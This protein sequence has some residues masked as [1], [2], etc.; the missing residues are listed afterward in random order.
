MIF[1][2]SYSYSYTKHYIKT[3]KFIQ[4]VAD[5]PPITEALF[6]YFIFTVCF[7][8]ILGLNN[9]LYTI[10]SELLT[11]IVTQRLKI[12]ITRT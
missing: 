7:C 3:K 6:I 5:T 9:I 8:T 11:F 2:I 10:Y 1:F 4:P 12:I